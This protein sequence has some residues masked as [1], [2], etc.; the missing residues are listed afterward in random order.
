MHIV[1]QIVILI[2]SATLHEV[3]HGYVAYAL[4]DPTAKLEGRLTLNPLKHLELFGSFILPLM[5]Y[6]ATAGALVFGWA[7]PVPYNPYNLRGGKWG[8]AY[9][10]LAGPV[11]NLLLAFIFGMIVRLG[12]PSLSPAFITLSTLIV[13]INCL[14]AVFNLLP[15]PPLDGSKVLFALLPQR[16]SAIEEMFNRYQLVILLFILFFGWRIIQWP[17]LVLSSLFLGAPLS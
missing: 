8:P 7:K 12:A 3:S 15:V 1:F 14:L 13:V 10:A 2:L 5:M 4:G 6:L 11:S 16:A 9:V 17:V